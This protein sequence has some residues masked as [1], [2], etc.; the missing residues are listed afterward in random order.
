M[1]HTKR[2][3]LNRIFLVLGLLGATVAVVR[4][5]PACTA[6]LNAA[7][8]A[9]IR[10]HESDERRDLDTA[11]EKS[12]EARACFGEEDSLSRAWT[13]NYE[14]YALH[15][16]VRFGEA[17]AVLDTFFQA[18]PVV[19]DSTLWARMHDR[20]GFVAKRMGA[21]AEA[22]HAFAEAARYAPSLP[23]HR[24]AMIYASQPN[25]FDLMGDDVRALALYER[26]ADQLRAPAETDPALR[27]TLGRAL[28]KAA[29]ILRKLS[30]GN[31]ETLWR[32][33]ASAREALQ[34]LEGGDREAEERV[35]ATF[36]L[37]KILARLGETE[38][39]SS[40]FHQAVRDADLFGDRMTRTEAWYELGRWQLGHGETDA[41][42]ASLQQAL[43]LALDYGEHREAQLV[44]SALGEAYEA[45]GLWDE[46]A[47]H[48][49]RAIEKVERHRASL[50]T[51]TW[52]AT[53]FAQ[54]QEP[55]RNLAR[56][57]LS[58]D[59][60]EDAFVTLERT[61]ARALYDLRRS[62]HDLTQLG[63]DE[64]VRLDS[65]DR[66][67]E[68]LRETLGPGSPTSLQAHARL[69]ALEA[70]RYGTTDAGEY[71][72]PTP[73]DVQQALA[74]DQAVLS[75]FLTDEA[76]YVFVVTAEA[77]HAV[78]LDVT[79]A[80]VESLV[81]SIS[82]LWHP[83]AGA[84][85]LSA[86]AFETDPLHTLYIALVAPVVALLPPDASLVVIPDGPLV[87]LPFAMLLEAPTPRFQYAEAQFLIRRHPI[88]TELAA[89]M[90]TAPQPS[91][92]SP[93]FDVLAFGRS[94]FAAPAS[95]LRADSGYGSALPDLPVVKREIR[96][97]DRLFPR[98]VVAL[99]AEASEAAL[100]DRLGK[101][102][103]V[104]LASHATVNE[105][106]P[107]YSHIDLWP[108]T[109]ASED[110][111]IYLYELAGRR[112]DADLVVLSGCSTARGQ[113]LA[114]EGMNGLQ[115]A[116]RAAGAGASV[117]T[118]WHVD[119]KASGDLMERFYLHL[120]DGMPKDR[121][122][123]QAQLDYLA[124]A[125]GPRASPF[126]WAAP[127]LYGNTAPLEWAERPA[128]SSVG[129]IGLGLVLIAL[130]L[131]LPRFA[132]RRS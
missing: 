75:Y 87:R 119:D 39:P 86:T 17:R 10:A 111:Q 9:S 92:T 43:D 88:S 61:R 114:G 72:P 97:L 95:A 23:L 28:W 20:S 123:R 126:F 56:I 91:Q 35:Y 12:R 19:L 42:L 108:D 21:F 65:L 93:E 112:M 129:W 102:R 96:M 132:R 74:P 70:E 53:A 15:K 45:K 54:W 57:Q 30:R 81:Q 47:K 24:Q 82:P 78:P 79:A 98:S 94:D 59:Q 48:Y 80:D 52:A 120:R 16:L 31:A 40:L 58:Q 51:T 3:G 104:H 73:T 34:I 5:Q 41:A 27:V 63:D 128:L 85:T 90:L 127:V 100:D 32:A 125:R 18:F 115:Y 118:L 67:I 113:V 117:A 6:L 101:A 46:A 105:A 122:L 55:Y 130:G 71:A 62:N 49:R 29:G 2:T 110:G 103:V 83:G 7:E 99:D 109:T 4:A 66:E 44:L 107:L 38:E 60:P 131:A 8:W 22:Q 121:A 13:Y 26:L 36:T 77:F 37:A 89:V 69:A 1:Q 14:V 124:E 76:S 116:F 33:E 106:Q 64:R 50:G 11:L 84:P 68:R 25:L